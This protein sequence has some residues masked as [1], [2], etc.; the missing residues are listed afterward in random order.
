MCVLL[1]WTRVSQGR[2]QCELAESV[3]ESDP[4]EHQL[5][6]VVHDLNGARLNPIGHVLHLVAEVLQEGVPCLHQSQAGDLD[7]ELVQSLAVLGV[8]LLRLVIISPLRT[9]SS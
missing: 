6:L 2:L 9:T 5:L 3:L 8:P 1:G 7:V 4:G